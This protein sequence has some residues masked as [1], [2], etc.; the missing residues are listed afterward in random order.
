MKLSDYDKSLLAGEQGKARQVAMKMMV[1]AAEVSNAQ[2]LVD[3]QMAHVNSCFY[4][5][6]LGVEFA[7]FL[8]NEGGQLTVPT[9]TNVGLVD[10]LHP[11]LRPKEVHPEEV[12]GARTLMD[13]Y[14]QLGCEVVWTCA[15]YQLK[16][17]PGLGDQIVGS[18]SNAV[19]FYNSVLGARTNKY[20]DFLDICAAITGRAP[21]SGL[22]LT[23]SRRGQLLFRLSGVSDALLDE[24][25]FYH[26]LGVI[27][28][29]EAGSKAPVV[30]GLPSGV[31]EDRLKA[32]SAAAAAAGAVN[33]F[34]AVGVT[35]EANS[36]AEAFQVLHYTDQTPEA[37]IEVTPDKLKAAR[38]LLSNTTSTE[39][40]A[41]C[42]GTPHFSFSEFQQLIGYL[43]ELP[44]G[45]KRHP[46]ICFYLSTSRFILDQ[47]RER[48]WQQRLEDF[49]IT[50]VV[51]T[52]TYFTPVAQG[53]T[54]AVMTNS[55]KWAYYAPGMLKV[56]VQFGSM[57]ECVI[58]AV[59]GKLVRDEN[60]WSEQLWNIADKRI[61][62][63]ASN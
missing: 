16:N 40:R 51:D 13:I 25:I 30:E 15:P 54:G 48:G 56:P 55:G 62:L 26:L 41:V 31:C 34:H 45:S 7:R 8:L 52:C 63:V 17:R 18:E 36:L 20:G 46:D 4:S 24:D 32:V 10:L 19:V 14:R 60:L 44:E 37:I 33:L 1:K 27:L 9:L 42:L 61:P 2:G 28:G 6:E 39:L 47:I 49:G 53:I 50:L 38:E 11:D 58:S 57:R 59:A 21:A 3:I 43:N 12:E 35:P 5:G 23:E 22:H 29:R